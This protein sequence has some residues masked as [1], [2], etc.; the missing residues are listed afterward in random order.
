MTD[1]PADYCAALFEAARAINSSLSLPEVLS[2]IAES[3][4][5]AMGAKGCVIRLLSPVDHTLVPGAVYG[6]SD[7]YIAKGPV[8][9]RY[10][11]VDREALKGQVVAIEDATTDRR[12][13]YP[14]EAAEEGI[15]SMLVAPLES[16]G[17]ALG[18]IRI[19]TAEPRR[20]GES[21]K[22][23]LRFVAELSAIAIGNA[24]AFDALR[25][26]VRARRQAKR[27]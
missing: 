11:A 7:Q 24:R 5:R 18:V 12:L 20:F 2:R 19:Y 6:L 16:R 3:T 13:Q 26:E 1:Q 21:E 22:C 15:R 10:S 9:V 23:L 8:Q 14:H 27:S 4:A 17:A 25:Q